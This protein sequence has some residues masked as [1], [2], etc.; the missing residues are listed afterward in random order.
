MQRSIAQSLVRLA[1]ALLLCTVGFWTPTTS[2]QSIPFCECSSTLQCEQ[3][4][5]P[6]YGCSLTGCHE[7]NGLTGLCRPKTCPR[8]SFS[9]SCIQVIVW[10]ANP[11]TGECCVYPN[12]CVVPEGWEISYTGCLE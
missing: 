12:P 1:A 8:R 11:Q 10:A 5:G 6:N 9:G 7:N 2:A 4:Y 3:R